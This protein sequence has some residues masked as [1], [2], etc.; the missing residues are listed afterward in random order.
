M[1]FRTGIPLKPWDETPQPHKTSVENTET[2]HYIFDFEVPP[3]MGG[4]YILYAA[5]VVEGKDPTAENG[6]FY[7]RSNLA[8]QEITLD[9]SKDN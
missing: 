6:F 1:L 9:N 3:G 7:L 8:I 2:S 4:K 5:Y